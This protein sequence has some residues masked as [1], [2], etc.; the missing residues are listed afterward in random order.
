MK[1]DKL[2]KGLIH[3]G[4]LRSNSPSPQKNPPPTKK[5]VQLL[6]Q[7]ISEA[8]KSEV[9]L[10]LKKIIW[11]LL[12]GLVC[13]PW[14]QTRAWRETLT[15]PAAHKAA[16][17]P[18]SLSGARKENRHKNGLHHREKDSSQKEECGNFP[19]PAG[20]QNFQQPSAAPMAVSY[21]HPSQN[22]FLVDIIHIPCHHCLLGAEADGLLCGGCL[23]RPQAIT[24]ARGFGL[25][26][27]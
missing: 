17:T 23:S 20:A 1:E 16:P 3:K 12:A 2:D 15:S 10:I 9:E 8:K 18:H 6:A 14:G 21:P 4:G 27:L 25:W 7:A 24:L 5:Q 22:L 19:C 13:K 11:L 26:V